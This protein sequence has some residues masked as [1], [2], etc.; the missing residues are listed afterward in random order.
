MNIGRRAERARAAESDEMD[1]AADRMKDETIIEDA[2][3]IPP[4]E[5]AE[6]M[7]NIPV[8]KEE[9]TAAES[10]V[11]E[12]VS[13]VQDMEKIL[14]ATLSPR[15][16]AIIARGFVDLGIQTPRD[17]R[18]I[19]LKRSVGLIAVELFATAFNALMTVSMFVL[20][21]NL[22]YNPY[23]AIFPTFLAYLSFA[24]ILVAGAIFAVETAAHFILLSAYIYSLVSFETADLRK[25]V[26]A[27]QRLGDT[28]HIISAMTPSSMRRATSS[29]HVLKILNDIRDAL[30]EEAELITP[31]HSTL[32]NLAAYFELS[33]AQSKFGF[34]SENYG[35]SD[36][37]AMRIASLF[38]EHDKDGTGELDGEK[39]K[40]LLSSMGHNVTQ[41]DTN[42]ALRLLDKE[43]D[44][45]VSLN[46]FVE[47]YVKGID[48]PDFIAQHAKSGGKPQTKI[49]AASSAVP[50]KLKPKSQSEIIQDATPSNPEI[51]ADTFDDA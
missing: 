6:T 33:N 20:S 47:W 42:I 28:E 30:H 38:S 31:T 10:A 35:I 29:M 41:M 40:A 48:V 18:R 17:L 9:T 15:A 50:P 8:T 21:I 32:H 2:T 14:R 45:I 22:N 23:E 3:V 37:E 46:E 25:F 26:E 12:D 39:L 34:K 7:W 11:D 51:D 24:M 43:E 4:A 36:R 5:D 27:T 44:G 19:V 16:A 1:V 49:G 13:A